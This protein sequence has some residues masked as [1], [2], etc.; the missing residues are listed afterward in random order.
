MQTFLVRQPAK[1]RGARALAA[2]NAAASKQ[3]QRD[4]GTDGG[5]KPKPEAA[6]RLNLDFSDDEDEEEADTN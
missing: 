3:G 5:A 1:T 4:K 2:K 6:L